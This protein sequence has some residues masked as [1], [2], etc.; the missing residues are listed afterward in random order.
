MPSTTSCGVGRRS[1]RQSQSQSRAEHFE[2]AG[3][4]LDASTPQSGV[5]GK[6]TRWL[7][8][9]MLSI[10]CFPE[11]MVTY[12]GEQGQ[13]HTH[14]RRPPR[15][16]Q[17]RAA[18]SRWTCDGRAWKWGRG[19]RQDSVRG[20]CTPGCFGAC[21]SRLNNVVNTQTPCFFS[22]FF[23]QDDAEVRQ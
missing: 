23:F 16:V 13:P 10:T 18:R 14:T 5:G 2:S 6:C 4:R 20:T 17:R 21:V 8:G 11:E 3:I 1:A 9:P 15:D 22:C 19:R 7:A 12:F